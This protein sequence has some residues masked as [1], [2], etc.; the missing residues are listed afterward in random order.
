[1][2][3]IA[4]PASSSPMRGK[5]FLL[6]ELPDPK[7]RQPQVWLPQER[8]AALSKSTSVRSDRHLVRRRYVAEAEREHALGEWDDWSH[9]ALPLESG[10]G[11]DDVQSARQSDSWR[12]V[13]DVHDQ[14]ALGA[15]IDDVADHDQVSGR[16][17]DYGY[18]CRRAHQI[19]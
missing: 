10:G 13:A 17:D 7:V 15:A 1:M 14:T 6:W 5:C 11:V 19:R 16:T 8:D 4:S 12:K 3:L 2:L 9:H 18:G